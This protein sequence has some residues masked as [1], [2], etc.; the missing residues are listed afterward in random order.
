MKKNHLL[1]RLAILAT[2]GLLSFSATPARAT[3]LNLG[4]D[5]MLRGVSIHERD[6]GLKNNAYYDQ[7]LQAYLTTD[8]S[9]DVEASIRIQSITPWG[10]ENSTTT[11]ATRYPSANG[12]PWIQNAFVRMPHIYKDSIVLTVGRQPLAWGD[13]HIL[14]DDELGFNAIRLQ[15]KSPWQKFDFD[16]DAFTAK[17]SEGL[18]SNGDTD[19]H[20]AMIST[21]R[22]IFKWELMG[23]WENN[24]SNENYQMGAETSSVAV[25]HLK[26]QIYGVRAQSNLKDAYLKGEYYIQRGEVDRKTS[27]LS[28]VELGGRAYSFGLGGKSNNTKFGRFG[29]AADYSEGSGDNPDTL[30]TDEAFRAPFASRWSGLER[31]GNGRY[32]ASTFSDVYSSSNP[33]SPASSTNTGLPGGTSGIQTTHFGMDATPWSKWTF[34]F[35][36]YQYKAIK[37]LGGDKELGNEFDFG[38]IFRYSG[39]VVVR[40]TTT[41]FKPGKAF[42]QD[43]KQNGKYSEVQLDLK[44]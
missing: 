40:A 44:F 15:A 32:F 1:K 29:A 25:P 21:Q 27:G 31:S 4:A 6:K 7:R 14:A 38:L 18:Q 16:F 12:T 36:Y 37:N 19:L 5:Y 11:L 42:N 35:D 20:G 23:L 13:G 22:E 39:L 9:Q 26:R 41:T 28:N 34:T 2:P 24:N 8:L 30:G 10:M 17:I 33:F 43:T 3:N